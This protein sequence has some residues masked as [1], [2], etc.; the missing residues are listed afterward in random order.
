MCK[1]LTCFVILLMLSISF[2]AVQSQGAELPPLTELGPYEIGLTNVKL[3]DSQRTDWELNV[4][5]WY[6]AD[7]SG[8][9]PVMP[10]LLARRDAPPDKSGAPYPL[11]IYS[12]GWSGGPIRLSEVIE[13]L[14]SHGYVVA[15]IDHNDTSPIRFELV[16]RPLDILLVLDSLAAVTDGDLAGM[17][18]T[19]D[20]GLMGY[21]QGAD[22]V[23]QMVGLLRDPVHYTTWCAEPHAELKTT[24]CAPS[25]MVVGFRVGQWPF[26]E[27]TEYRTQLGL[28]N[29]SDGRWAPF[30]D[31]RIRAV[32]A[33]AACDFPLTTEDMLAEVTTPTMLIHGTADVLCDYE[34]NA[35]R[36]YTHLGS[37]DRYLVTLVDGD[38][39][40][41]LNWPKVPQH[42]ATAFF[43]Y[44]L[45]GDDTYQS[46]LTPEAVPTWD[47][48][49]LAW[50]PFERD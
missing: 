21:S 32:L 42:F 11:I 7:K 19:Q 46:Y 33:M 3:V 38:H 40:D 31:P 25:V 27:I 8:G 17:M 49:K 41:L 45:Q 20:V 37:E 43:G 35:V 14:V 47:I 28:E 22:A 39:L 4:F 34:G 12:P 36:T 1:R 16:D 29:T 2:G 9:R 48:P 18:N 30:G 10:D 26:A 50:G 15:G 5:V 44:Y 13:P 24:E 23:L 6:P